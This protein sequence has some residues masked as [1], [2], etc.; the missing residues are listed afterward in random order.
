MTSNCDYCGNSNFKRYMSPYRYS[1]SYGSDKIFCCQRCLENYQDKLV[2]DKER[3]EEEERIADEQFRQKREY[4]RERQRQERIDLRARK[5]E[6]F[7]NDLNSVI[8][9]FSKNNNQSG[10]NTRPQ[11]GNSG[12]VLLLAGLV[13]IYL[14]SQ[15]IF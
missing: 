14:A 13:L 3:R 12:C 2:R 1:R 4:E 6:E 10:T 7:K 11:A 8:Q 5:R 15:I 9:F